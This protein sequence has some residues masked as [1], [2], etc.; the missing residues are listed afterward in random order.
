MRYV[1]VSSKTY[2]DNTGRSIDFPTLLVEYNGET[3]LLE[4]LHIYQIK[5]RGKSRTWHKKLVQAVGL[6]LDYMEANLNCYFSAKE[7]FDTFTESVYSGTINEE[8]L[9]PSG[10]Y[11]LPKRVET[12]NMLLSALNRLSDWL[13]EEYGAV[14]LNPWRKATTYEERLNWMAQINKSQNSFL[15]HLDDVHDM[16]ETAKLARNVVKRKKP[17]SSNGDTKAFP[18][19]KIHELLWE[20]FKN[21][22][23]NYELDLVDRYNW[24]D[25]AITIL[26]NGGGLRHS[27][28]F[29]LWVQDVFP[30]PEDANLAVVRIYHPSEGRA[31]QD[32]KNPT[33]GKY[34]TDRESYLLLKYGL[35]PRNRYSAKDKRFA[36][37]KEPRLDNYDD[38]YMH[39]YWM[40]KE[41]GYIFMYVWRMYI[42]KRLRNGIKDTHPFAFV[43]HSP[44]T[45]GEMMPLRTQMESH[46]KAVEKIDLIVG[47]KYGTTPHGHRHAYGQRLKNANIDDR[48]KQV[49]MH[50][51]SIESQKVYTEPTVADV[52]VS[53]NNATA[54]LDNGYVLPMQTEID[55]WMNEETKLQ[56][57]YRYR[58]K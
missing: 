38:K 39:V 16:S 54:S 30:D 9:D 33:N 13:Y 4:Q 48:I 7:F 50:H 11:W 34:I 8:G 52:T 42:A 46:E 21:T 28:V 17:Y 2:R 45:L 15:G 51:K 23:K 26:M 18:E 47:K 12:A 57:R 43:S 35:L 27:E 6:L 25:I 41:W 36:G 3:M 1:Q 44:K 10:L 24:R 5:N 29:H 53:L 19:N 37:W 14:Q 56:N 22:R 31:P 32:F 20:G 55:A 58:R 49:A 40:S